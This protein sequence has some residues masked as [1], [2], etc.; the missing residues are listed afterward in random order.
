VAPLVA[1]MRVVRYL[2]EK[3]FGFVGNGEVEELFFH[4]RAFDYADWE[5]PSPIIGEFVEVEYDLLTP[6]EGKFPRA[7]KVRRLKK[8]V[9]RTGV[10]EHF[11]DVKGYGFIE[12][13]GGS[14]YL[15]RSEVLDGKLPLQ[16]HEVRFYEG[17][18]QNR[19]R[20]C[21]VEIG[22]DL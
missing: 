7:E 10:V 21:Y 2:P 17:F 15:H 11:D 19:I 4:L 20:A 3:M 18:K 12:M 5:K 14:A 13:E 1:Q 9:R 16:G 22:D 8:P 6:F